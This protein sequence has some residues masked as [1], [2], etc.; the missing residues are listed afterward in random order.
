MTSASIH[1]S[2]GEF[3]TATNA[4]GSFLVQERF[5]AVSSGS[6]SQAS[7]STGVA[8]KEDTS[9]PILQVS[10]PRTGESSQNTINSCP[11]DF[12]VDGTAST[13]DTDLSA[14]NIIVNVDEV[15]NK[16]RIGEQII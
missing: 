9:K 4:E 3:T 6:C 7:V 5:T 2:A 10:T 8:V 16:L 11:I 1:F 14:S 13:L 12:Y 15:V